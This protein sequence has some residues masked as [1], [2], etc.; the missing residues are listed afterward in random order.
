MY[1]TLIF[2]K[3]VPL[4]IQHTYSSEFSFGKR[5][6]EIYF[7]IWCEASISYFFYVLQILK[8]YSWNMKFQFK[9]QED[10]T[11]KECV[12][13]SKSFFT[14]NWYSKNLGTGFIIFFIL[15]YKLFSYAN[16]QINNCSQFLDG[17]KF[18]VRDISVSNK[19]KYKNKKK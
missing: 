16:K 17:L 4:S 11:C 13:L 8:S 12:V 15:L 1:E 3:L 18:T 9:K 19:W 5:T 7:L 2:F 10:I 14:K 6:Y